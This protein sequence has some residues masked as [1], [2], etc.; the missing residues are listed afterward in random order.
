VNAL[1]RVH[2]ALV[3]EGILLDLMPFEAWIPVETADQELGHLDAREF[4]R[5]ARQAESGLARTVRDGLYAHEREVR[6]HV[7]EHFESAERFLDIV[8]NW[9][10]TRIPTRL[11]ARIAHAEP[12]FRV[13]QAL[14]LRR[15]RA[16]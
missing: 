9:R 3:P 14:V 13:R 2:E 1:R 8:G 10:G 6:F 5:D 7:L 12:P 16:S 11:R 4:A 15:L